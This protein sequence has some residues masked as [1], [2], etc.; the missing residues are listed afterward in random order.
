MDVVVEGLD[1]VDKND[2]DPFAVA[3]LELRDAGDVSLDE[4]E[5]DLRAHAA[6]NRARG[7]AQVAPAGGDELDPE[8]R[9]RGH[10]SSS[11]RQ[12]AGP[13]SSRRPRAWRRRSPRARATSRRTRA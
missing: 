12:R 8:A 6:D 11:R 2:G 7:V 10:A 3:G 5:L 9:G 1:A 4:I 13:L